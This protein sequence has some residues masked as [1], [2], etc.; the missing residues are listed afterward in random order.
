MGVREIR[1]G[2]LILLIS[3]T[4]FAVRMAARY[5]ADQIKNVHWSR[6]PYDFGSWRGKDIEFNPLYGGDPADTSLLRVYED[7]LGGQVIVYVGFH[8]DLPSG[9][10]E[11]TPRLCYPSQGWTILSSGTQSLGPPGRPWFEAREMVVGEGGQRRV[12]T[13]WYQT[14]HRIFD[15]RIRHVYELMLKAMWTGRTDGVLAR[16]EAPIG[17]GGESAARQ[18]I[19]R[20]AQVFL[21]PLEHALP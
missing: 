13:W 14:G 5:K 12:V 8:R 11:H 16:L 1:L 18:R 2:A 9:L 6:V 15:K 3:G 10:D 17:P 21:P 20:F 7:P 19:A 4:F